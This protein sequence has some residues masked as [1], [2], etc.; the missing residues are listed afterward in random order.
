MRD[1]A[2]VP[3]ARRGVN[4]VENLRQAMS[5][6]LQ[7]TDVEAGPPTPQSP[8]WTSMD[9][10]TEAADEVRHAATTTEPTGAQ[11]LS[12]T[13][14][15]VGLV[16]AESPELNPLETKVDDDVPPFDLDAPFPL[17]QGSISSPLDGSSPPS[18]TASI[19]PAAKITTPPAA[20]AP[21][22]ADAVIDVHYNGD[23]TIFSDTEVS[24]IVVDSSKIRALPP[25]MLPLFSSMLPHPSSPSSEGLSE[26]G[27]YELLAEDDM[28]I[29]AL[30]VPKLAHPL[31][32]TEPA[33]PL[34]PAPSPL[35]MDLVPLPPSSGLLDPEADH[36]D[37][38]GKGVSM[39]MVA[40][41]YDPAEVD[42]VEQE[43]L[44]DVPTSTLPVT[45][46]G[47]SRYAVDHLP[48]SQP[49]QGTSTLIP[50]A[51][52]KE[53]EDFDQ[54]TAGETY[55][56]EEQDS[57]PDLA[58]ALS[59]SPTSL[60]YT[61]TPATR[62]PTKRKRGKSKYYQ[63]TIQRHIQ[64]LD[65]DLIKGDQLDSPFHA[66]DPIGKA[67]P[68]TKGEQGMYVGLDLL[69]SVVTQGS[70]EAAHVGHNQNSY[71]STE[72]HR[73]NGQQGE[74]G[75][76]DVESPEEGGPTAPNAAERLDQSSESSDPSVADISKDDKRGI[77]ESVVG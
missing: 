42:D 44:S 18:S 39:P 70:A 69:A 49:P 31:V 72:P 12:L 25:P 73:V 43:T 56:E 27:Q 38:S 50:A 51:L 36:N 34:T 28:P 48:V 8:L 54:S 77:L 64:E 52:T 3:R 63:L 45:G 23:P 20:E 65:K 57:M 35:G 5:L 60:Q 67:L 26:D 37:L 55:L 16:N 66:H 40:H 30:L 41:D 53:G 68:T 19:P 9:H 24:I 17:S 10:Y 13:L 11:P 33:H 59:S 46:P 58:A 4:A 74:Q 76:S 29:H 2:S 15:P 7:P 14:Q 6:A 22:A 61:P 47:C 71:L 75:D 1:A 32:P 62:T 21:G